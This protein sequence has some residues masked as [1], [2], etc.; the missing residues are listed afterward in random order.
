MDK[1][2]QLPE[3][4]TAILLQ[5]NVPDILLRARPVNIVWK[6]IIDTSPRLLW[7]TWKLNRNLH[8][9]RKDL[10]NTV[11]PNNILIEALKRQ[12]VNIIM[13]SSP[14]HGVLHE[15]T[16]AMGIRWVGHRYWYY[17][18]KLGV[19]GDPV[20]EAILETALERSKLRCLARDRH[21]RQCREHCINAS[22][23]YISRF[24]GSPGIRTAL[25]NMYMTRPPL[26]KMT[27]T[28]YYI[29]GGEKIKVRVE[30]L[31]IK[32]LDNSRYVTASTFLRE[33]SWWLIDDEH[34]QVSA[35]VL[36]EI[37][38]YT[39]LE[40]LFCNYLQNLATVSAEKESGEGSF[41]MVF[42]R[43][44]KRLSTCTVRDAPWW[45]SEM[46]VGHEYVPEG[47]WMS[48]LDPE[49]SHCSNFG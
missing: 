41:E 20:R 33:V 48:I 31:V 34:L 2:F 37:A 45:D 49:L 21:W 7:A 13:D 3:L 10:S 11:E 8:P 35:T 15:E 24:E 38:A 17:R 4:L 1:V 23:C 27:I 36:H 39:D 42:P 32:E 9:D 47:V 16:K 26:R 46:G 18:C 29:H 6:E 43:T 5:L 22:A 28:Y 19:H 14:L 25:E 40:F 44:L 30:D 12:P